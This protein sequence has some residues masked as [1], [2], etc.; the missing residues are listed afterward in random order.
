MIKLPEREKHGGNARM[1]WETWCG[2]REERRKAWSTNNNS[3]LD[4]KK[5]R[6][7]CGAMARTG[8]G[9]VVSGNREE[10][11]GGGP[12]DKQAA[13]PCLPRVC[14]GKRLYGLH[15]CRLTFMASQGHFMEAPKGS[16]REVH[17]CSLWNNQLHD[18]PQCSALRCFPPIS[19]GPPKEIRLPT[20]N[21]LGTR[22]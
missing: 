9:R 10:S 8:E 15:L 7:E 21:Y 3:E 2:G 22:K 1:K 18:L 14:I 5:V 11:G 6:A 4:P 12:S 19:D 20:L 17:C 13:A 16:W